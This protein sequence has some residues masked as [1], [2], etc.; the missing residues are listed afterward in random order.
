V[1]ISSTIAELDGDGIDDL[2][3]H[4]RNLSGEHDVDGTW[5]LFGS[6][7]G[8]L[9]APERIDTSQLAPANAPLVDDLDQDGRDE[10]VLVGADPAKPRTRFRTVR[11][12]QNTRGGDWN[13]IADYALPR[14]LASSAAVGQ[15]REDGER[16]VAVPIFDAHREDGRMQLDGGIAILTLDELRGGGSGPG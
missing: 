3:M 16:G 9:R 8:K 11:V 5:V 13:R 1:S 15:L 10:V 14:G 12:Y 4:V 6:R 7:D 2:V